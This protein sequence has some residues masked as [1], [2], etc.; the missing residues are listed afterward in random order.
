VKRFLLEGI[1]GKLG[2]DEGGK[3]LWTVRGSCPCSHRAGQAEREQSQGR[4]VGGYGE[5]SK[6]IDLQAFFIRIGAR[7]KRIRKRPRGVPS[8]LLY[9]YKYEKLQELERRESEG[10]IALYYADENH[11]CTGGYVP[12]GWQLPGEEVFIASQR[13]ARLNIFGMI[14]PKNHYEGFSTTQSI[15]ADRVVSFLD[16]FSFRVRKDTFVVLD[17]AET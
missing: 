4:L 10:R 14:D 13:T 1:T 11:V 2:R 12:Y 9:E 15:T 6:R 16:A 3:L 5:R 7:Y 17:D 8:P